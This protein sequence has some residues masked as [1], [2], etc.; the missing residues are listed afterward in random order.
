MLLCY[1]GDCGKSHSHWYLRAGAKFHCGQFLGWCWWGEGQPLRLSKVTKCWCL[2][3]PNLTKCPFSGCWR[4]WRGPCTGNIAMSTFL[5]V[6]SGNFTIVSMKSK[7]RVYMD[8]LVLAMLMVIWMYDN[9]FAG[10]CGEAIWEARPFWG[11]TQSPE[12]ELRA[13]VRWSTF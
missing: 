11:G 13:S 6:L 12:G 10:E 9:F 1:Y 7:S 5:K 2:Q 8:I 3:S 4:R